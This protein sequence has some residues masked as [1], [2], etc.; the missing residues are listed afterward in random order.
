MRLLLNAARERICTLKFGPHVK[1]GGS[2]AGAQPPRGGR[3]GGR[4]ARKRETP[5]YFSI[6]ALD[7][8]LCCYALS[9]ITLREKDSPIERF[10]CRAWC[11]SRWS[12][13]RPAGGRLMSRR[14]V[15]GGDPTTSLPDG[16]R[17]YEGCRLPDATSRDSVPSGVAPRA[18]LKCKLGR[19]QEN[20]EKHRSL[21]MAPVHRRREDAILTDRVKEAG[22][23]VNA[24]TTFSNF[25][26]KMFSPPVARPPPSERDGRANDRKLSLS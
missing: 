13:A 18:V 5:F 22:K 1:G 20:G 11:W 10:I 25:L 4:G 6:T 15:R 24:H 8:A 9:S 21:L 12:S 23:S 16:N 14:L 3:G 7:K 17:F 2:A 19:F 26:Q